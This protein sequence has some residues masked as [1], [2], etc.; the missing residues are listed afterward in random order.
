MKDL[1]TALSLF[2]LFGVLLPLFSQDQTLPDGLYAEI[3]TARGTIV[4]SLEYEKA[5]MTVSS[6]VGLAEGSISANGVGGRK[7]F[8]GLTF[9]RVDPG[10]VI[11]GGTPTATGRGGPATS[12][13]TRPGPT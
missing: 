4:C 13:P 5:P 11:Q 7:F 9:H 8:D 6:F 1:R 2:L 12:F 10:F 3:T